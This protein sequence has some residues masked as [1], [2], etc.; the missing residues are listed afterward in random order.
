MTRHVITGS[1]GFTG[2]IMAAR[3]AQQ[4]AQVVLFDHAPPPFLP[5]GVRFV[6]GDVCKMEDVA[7]IGLGPD[8][9]VH[10][11]AARQFHL[12]VPAKGATP[13]SRM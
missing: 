5:K 4:G 13:G 9:A 10:H 6:H 3:L 7:R 12:A 1:S 11:L 2:Q 8:D